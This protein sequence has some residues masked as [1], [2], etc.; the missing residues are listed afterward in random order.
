MVDRGGLNNDMFIFVSTME[1]VVQAFLKGEGK[2]RD[3]KSKMIKLIHESDT[4]CREWSKTAA[5]WEPEKSQ[6]I[7]DM[8]TD[9]WVTMCGFSYASE[10]MEKWK[11]ETKKPVQISTTKKET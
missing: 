4:V 1:L 2:P 5:E 3:I 7:F 9:L 11:Q 6:L 10:W 8:V